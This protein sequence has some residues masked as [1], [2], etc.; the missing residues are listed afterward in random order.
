MPKNSQKF[1]IFSKE[2]CIRVSAPIP[3]LIHMREAKW[4]EKVIGLNDLPPEPQ[5]ENEYFSIR[6]F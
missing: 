3:F 5:S 1:C 6:N 2:N 4:L